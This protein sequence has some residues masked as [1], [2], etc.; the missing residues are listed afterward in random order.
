MARHAK[1][2]RHN[3]LEKEGSSWL[4]GD[5]AVAGNNGG[6]LI[7]SGSSPLRTAF[8]HCRLALIDV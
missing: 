4:G 3:T 6:K 1:L 7:G 5:W 2:C 8:R